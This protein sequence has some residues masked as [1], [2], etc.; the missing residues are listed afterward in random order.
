MAEAPSTTTTPTPPTSSKPSFTSPRIASKTEAGEALSVKAWL[1]NIKKG[2]GDK[3]GDALEEGG[4][5]EDVDD[6][7]AAAPSD[8]ELKEFLAGAG[9]K[10][11]RGFVF[12]LQPMEVRATSKRASISETFRLRENMCRCGYNHFVKT[13]SQKGCEGVDIRLGRSEVVL[14]SKLEK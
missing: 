9:A 5:Y 6:I 10:S 11:W 2:W 4:G 12:R 7:L 3:Y 14:H 8:D 1:D 13:I